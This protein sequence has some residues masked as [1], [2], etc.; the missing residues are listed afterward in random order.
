MTRRSSK[1]ARTNPPT[2]GFSRSHRPIN[3]KSRTKK[4]LAARACKWPRFSRLQFHGTGWHGRRTHPGAWTYAASANTSADQN[5]GSRRTARDTAGARALSRPQN[6]PHGSTQRPGSGSLPSPAPTAHASW[7]GAA[8]PVAIFIRARHPA[9]RSLLFGNLP[10][11]NH[12]V[13]SLA[14]LVELN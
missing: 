9:P 2:A 8:T 6:P 4:Q 7:S 3:R 1:R 12:P 11:P 5:L 14:R 13:D 10:S